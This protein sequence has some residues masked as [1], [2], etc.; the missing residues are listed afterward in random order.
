MECPSL[1]S[2]EI[3]GPEKF[4]PVSGMAL[5][6]LLRCLIGCVMNHGIVTGLFSKSPIPSRDGIWDAQNA[7]SRALFQGVFAKPQFLSML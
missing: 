4:S 6:E 3:F 2:P 5:E 1:S 7:K